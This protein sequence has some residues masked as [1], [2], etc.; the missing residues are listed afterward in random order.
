MATTKQ[1]TIKV[2][3][4]ISDGDYGSYAAEYTELIEFDEGDNVSA[5]VKER[6]E[7]ARKRVRITL[8]R[9]KKGDGE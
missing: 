7:Y 4:K 9:M 5:V 6:T 1:V 8:S 2:G 3:R